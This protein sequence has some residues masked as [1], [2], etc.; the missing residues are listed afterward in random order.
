[1]RL[2]NIFVRQ[3]VGAQWLKKGRPA[4]PNFARIPALADP[5]DSYDAT[6]QADT[7][8]GPS[9]RAAPTGRR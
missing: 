7:R 9:R 3:F 2:S 4:H 5:P 1:M 8:R 6:K